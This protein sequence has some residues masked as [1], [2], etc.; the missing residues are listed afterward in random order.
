MSAF[1]K[2]VLLLW[3]L[4]LLSANTVVLARTRVR[5]INALSGNQPL[6]VHCKSKDDDLGQ[7]TV[8][9]GSFYEFSFGISYIGETLFFCSFQ[10]SGASHNFD[11]YR[12]KRDDKV[13]GDGCF[14]NIKQTGP[15][16]VLPAPSPTPP[17]F[18]WN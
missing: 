12:Y 2:S 14:W 9:P 7:H 13:C 8:Y 5:I 4:T 16:R 10:W 3:V 6:S 17:C 11:I 1:T 18:P 15:C